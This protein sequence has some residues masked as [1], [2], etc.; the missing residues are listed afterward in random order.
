MWDLESGQLV[1]TLEGHTH[2]VTAVVLMPDGRRA[3]SG[4]ADHTLR[5]WDLEKGQLV[6]TLEG[7]TDWVTAVVVTP[8][9]R[10]AISGSADRTLR[11]WDLEGGQSA[12]AL[13]GHADSV[14]AV[15][16]MPDG[17]SR[18]LGLRLPSAAF[19]GLGERPIA[20]DA[21]RPYGLG[22]RRSRNAR[23]APRRLG[24]G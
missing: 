9:G 20:A 17:R 16:L 23:W 4:S 21:R 12:H 18:R 13:A 14:T 1:R 19:V 11:M 3:I 22:H 6:R 8:D 7:H 5:M 2:S 24:I 15:A 10:R